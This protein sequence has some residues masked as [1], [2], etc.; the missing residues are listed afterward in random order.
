MFEYKS[1]F[2]PQ[3]QRPASPLAGF[4]AARIIE[5]TVNYIQPHGV[6]LSA[7]LCRALRSQR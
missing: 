5:V 6:A 7:L 2:A 1:L 4:P 3:S